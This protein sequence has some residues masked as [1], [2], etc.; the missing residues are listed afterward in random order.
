MG[1]F[2]GHVLPGVLLFLLGSWWVFGTW[3]AYILSRLR[4]RNYWC[5]ASFA[6][7]K[8]PKKLCFEGLG[9]VVCASVGVAAETVAAFKH[10]EF[11]NVGSHTQHISM[12]IF[13]GLSGLADLLT[14][15]RA[16]IPRG[17]DY[18]ILLMTICV[19]GLLFHFK[20]HDKAHLDARLI[21]LLVYTIVAEA[22]CIAAEMVRRRS[23]LAALGRAFFGVVHATWLIQIG[24]V[25]YN[26][27]PNAKKW[28]E[29]HQN[30][31]LVTAVY[32]WHMIGVLTYVGLMGVVSWLWCSRCEMADKNEDGDDVEVGP[33]Y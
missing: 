19:E 8:L 31:M 2:T 1:S 29:N 26:P 7:P 9:K 17:T 12:Y 15:Y 27:L 25:L 21:E 5:T 24:F 33:T 18:S 23:T 28:E 30:M 3:R 20:L 6:L 22:A 32:T 16:P 11:T 13:Y 10:G 4:R 14:T